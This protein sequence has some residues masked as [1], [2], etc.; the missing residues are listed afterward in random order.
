[1]VFESECM[2][3]SPEEVK[4][5]QYTWTLKMIANKQTIAEQNFAKQQK[6]PDEKEVLR[7]LGRV[8]VKDGSFLPR[9]R[10]YLRI[11]NI[12]LLREALSLAAP[13]EDIDT[14]PFPPTPSLSPRDLQNM[15][16]VVTPEIIAQAAQ[17]RR[18]GLRLPSQDARGILHKPPTT[19]T[20]RDL[21]QSDP[22]L[23]LKVKKSRPPRPLG[24]SVVMDD[25][26]SNAEEG[27]EA[28]VSAT[29]PAAAHHA[30]RRRMRE[31]DRTSSSQTN[32]R[33]K[34]VGRHSGE[35]AQGPVTDE[36]ALPTL[37]SPTTP[38]LV[39]V[40]I[41]SHHSH[42]AHRTAHNP[43]QRAKD[44]EGGNP[45]AHPPA[46]RD[47]P[48]RLSERNTIP[49]ETEH[50][51]EPT[52]IPDHRRITKRNSRAEKM[53]EAYEMAFEAPQSA[54]AQGV[55]HSRSRNTEV[56][57]EAMGKVV[58][59][60]EA[61]QQHQVIPSKGKVQEKEYLKI[62]EEEEE[63]EKEVKEKEDEKRLWEANDGA[64]TLPDHPLGS[65][66][67]KGEEQRPVTE[68]A[69]RTEGVSTY[70]PKALMKDER[71]ST[72]TLLP[73]TPPIGHKAST[74]REK[75]TEATPP[76]SGITRESAL[77]HHAIS[78]ADDATLKLAVRTLDPLT[79]AEESPEW[80]EAERQPGQHPHNPEV[81]RSS[82]P[83]LLSPRSSLISV[84]SRPDNKEGDQFSSD[85]N[86]AVRRSE[87]PET[88]V[89]PQQLRRSRVKGRGGPPHTKM[90]EGL[91]DRAD[92][93]RSLG[94]IKKQRK[95]EK[96]KN[97]KT[98]RR[99]E[100]SNKGRQEVRGRGGGD[101]TPRHP[102]EQEVGYKENY[103]TS[104]VSVK[105]AEDDANDAQEAQ[106]DVGGAGEARQV[107]RTSRLLTHQHGDS[108]YTP[109]SPTPRTLSERGGAA[110]VNP[111][112]PA[113]EG[114]PWYELESKPSGLRGVGGKVKDSEPRHYPSEA[115]RPS[116]T[117]SRPGMFSSPAPLDFQIIPTVPSH[118]PKSAS[119]P[120]GLD[121]H[122]YMKLK[123]AELGH[124]KI[125]SH[126]TFGPDR[127]TG[128]PARKPDGQ[129]REGESAPRGLH[130]RLADG[131]AP[132][133]TT[134]DGMDQAASASQ[135]H[136]ARLGPTDHLEE[137]RHDAHSLATPT[138]H[139]PFS[140]SSNSPSGIPWYKMQGNQAWNARE[141]ASGDGSGS[142]GRGQ[143][144]MN[145][146]GV[147]PQPPPPREGRGR[148]SRG[149]GYAE[150]MADF[151]E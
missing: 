78:T 151:G 37:G 66:S 31:D 75:V 138:S 2:S 36:A 18:G 32:M 99:K 121:Y 69:P 42:L 47:P 148:A 130:P 26:P 80:H 137:E 12:S 8:K 117:H 142:I 91:R 57:W 83:P 41:G 141:A 124:R 55:D 19:R 125:D 77:L 44:K 131:K 13:E 97:M 92:L 127:S 53:I 33:R 82:L 51:T 144:E 128:N 29:A 150:D 136:R 15:P 45:A 38:A 79:E 98:E 118:S 14:A 114:L 21:E 11:Y 105:V 122:E 81:L 30:Q 139:S 64:H 89:L 110:A 48:P 34:V 24:N 146:P 65:G 43:R 1:M 133:H 149:P 60:E 9:P 25:L 52:E 102:W 73:D 70:A 20:K 96:L 135:R 143:N 74:A 101:A 111:E 72:I 88:T 93:Q 63:K 95:K 87:G 108:A 76:A 129:G 17:H 58:D 16:K 116:Q 145:P 4:A 90:A 134:E 94:K 62:E 120:W 50:Q 35:A 86:H 10:D 112:A 123:M 46:S 49:V 115:T 71:L 3:C 100:G 67:G 23:I 39:K 5:L 54:S 113:G 132:N 28:L 119:T 68:A 107:A 7:A 59:V 147:N 126:A 22:A 106:H 109:V 85:T 27:R 6:V 104:G 40:T 56:K 103:L 61:T 84:T 140:S